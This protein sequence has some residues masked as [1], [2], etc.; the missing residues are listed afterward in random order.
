MWDVAVEALMDAKELKEICRCGR[1]RGAS[2]AFPKCRA[3]VVALRD[4]HAF[5]NVKAVG[6]GIEV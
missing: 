4:D 6:E 1:C 5:P 3:E 2:F